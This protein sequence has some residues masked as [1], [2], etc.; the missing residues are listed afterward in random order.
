MVPSRANI[1]PVPCAGKHTSSALCGKT[2]TYALRG[3]T[4]SVCQIWESIQFVLSALGR[5][6]NMLQVYEGTSHTKPGKRKTCKPCISHALLGLVLVENKLTD[7]NAYELTC[8][9]FY[10][11]TTSSVLYQLE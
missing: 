5:I 6:Y 1:Q 7:Q 10:N 3:K 11:L 4:N 9:Q 8:F 2:Y